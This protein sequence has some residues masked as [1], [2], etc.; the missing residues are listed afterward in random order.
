MTISDVK[1]YWNSRPCNA[2]H[3]DIDI[4]THPLSYSREVTKRK[5]FVE[6]HI[7]HFMDVKRWRDKYV[8]DLG[9]GIGTQAILFARAGALVH[10][11][12][13]SEKSISIAE[14]R[15]GAEGLEKLFFT[16][17]NIEYLGDW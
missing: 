17:G 2:R 11:I 15:R 6:P 10:G 4:A 9:C 13:I 16:Q 5:L 1:R 7:I 14:E 8:L 3:S 12:D